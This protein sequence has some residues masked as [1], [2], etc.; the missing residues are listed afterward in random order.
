MTLAHVMIFPAHAGSVLHMKLCAHTAR[1]THT[2]WPDAKEERGEE[3]FT[4][5]TPHCS[6]HTQRLPARGS[7]S[8]SSR[9]PGVGRVEAAGAPPPCALQARPRPPPPRLRTRPR[10]P[11]P[12]HRRLAPLSYSPSLLLSLSYSLSLLSLL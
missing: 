4:H 10:N 12:R 1:I 3:S 5:A 11:R 2:A 7:L 9:Q 6:H 8:L